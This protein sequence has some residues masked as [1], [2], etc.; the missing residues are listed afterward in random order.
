M[1]GFIVFIVAFVLRRKSK[2]CINC[3]THIQNKAKFCT[4]CGKQ[5]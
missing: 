5:V 2:F 1:I 4:Q 3:G